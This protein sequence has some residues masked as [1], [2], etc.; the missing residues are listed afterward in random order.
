MDDSVLIDVPLGSPT[1]SSTPMLDHP[2]PQ[3]DCWRSV[4]SWV[5]C[6]RREPV[7]PY[8]DEGDDAPLC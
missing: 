2:K 7:S 8:D 4:L 1:S 6:R 3:R 5:R